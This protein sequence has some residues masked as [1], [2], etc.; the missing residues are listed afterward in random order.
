M[1]KLA[2]MGL[3]AVFAMGCTA[4]EISENEYE[5]YGTKKSEAVNSEGDSSDLDIKDELDNSDD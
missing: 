4:P 2:I 3:M 1:K 5:E